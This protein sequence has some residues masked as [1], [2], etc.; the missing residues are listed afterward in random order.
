M[1]ETIKLSISDMLK[2]GV[3]WVDY[4]EATD[5]NVYALREG[6]DEDTI[7]DCPIELIIP[8]KDLLNK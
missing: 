6:L 3:K 1:N 2:L 4:C 7:V 8:N 5:S